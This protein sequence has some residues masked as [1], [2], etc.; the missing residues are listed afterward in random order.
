MLWSHNTLQWL[1]WFTNHSNL[2]PAFPRPDHTIPRDNKESN[3]WTSIFSWKYQWPDN[4]FSTFTSWILV[5]N[6][7]TLPRLRYISPN[8]EHQPWAWEP[9]TE[10]GKPVVIESSMHSSSGQNIL[11]TNV[12]AICPTAESSDKLDQK[13]SVQEHNDSK[14]K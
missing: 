9:C 12:E 11:E 3:P 5:L 13:W 10:P 7:C 2:L 14:W 6:L 8:A 1:G 4:T